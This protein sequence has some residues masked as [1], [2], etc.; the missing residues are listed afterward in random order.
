MAIVKLVSASTPNPLTAGAGGDW[1]LAMAQLT[2]CKQ[3]ISG[4][5]MVL[6][7]WTNTDSACDLADG[8]Y[9]QHLGSIYVADA[10]VSLSGFVAGAN[11]VRLEVSG[12]TLVAT[13]I[14]SLTGYEWN[15]V[16]NGFYNG[17]YQVLP[18]MIDYVPSHGIYRKYRLLNI[19]S[20]L[21]VDFLGN[22]V[23]AGTLTATGAV[24]CASLSA[25]GAIAGAT[26]NTGQV[27]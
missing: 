22:T 6:T 16:Y 12:D 26:V 17:N 10:D 19:N 25:A 1:E 4:Q 11:Y 14:T 18:Y 24:Q 13:L 7:N 20:T 9:F 3:V 23:T 2:A 21:Y 5:Q 8:S 27:S 15:H